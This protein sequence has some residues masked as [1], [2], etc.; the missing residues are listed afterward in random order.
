MGTV[1]TEMTVTV[2]ARIVQKT[3]EIV[4]G[5]DGVLPGIG[6]EGGIE[7]GTMIGTEREREIVL[8]R[9]IEGEIGIRIEIGEGGIAGIGMIGGVMKATVPETGIEI[10]VCMYI[11][12]LVCR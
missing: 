12:M 3:A 9:M 11:C 4:T 2:V 8:H 10:E 6:I 5:T 1:V 7:I